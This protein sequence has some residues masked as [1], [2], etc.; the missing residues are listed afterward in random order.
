MFK[1]FKNRSTEEEIMDDFNLRGEELERTLNV[2]ENINQWLGGDLVLLSGMKEI[3][4]K[5]TDRKSRPI[6]ILDAGC[7]SGDSL[8]AVA[9]WNKKR[10][11]VL[12]LIG[13][14]ANEFTIEIAQKKAVNHPGIQ[15][16]A[17]DIFLENC[18]FV[19]VDV[20][21]CGLFMHH[22]T[23]EEQL[24]FLQ[25]CFDSDVKVVLVNDLHRHWLG[26]YLFQLICFLFR[27]PHMVKYDGSISI[28]KAFKRSDLQSLMHK[29]GIKNYDLRWRWAFRY[30]LIAYN[31]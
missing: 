26:Y 20:V 31:K 18:S 19:G 11:Y 13:L 7:G 23:E 27:V 12:N 8:R 4:P 28:L 2:I 3:L 24:S 6:T 15:F 10:G 1:K 21:V 29:A 14:D 16:L 30:Q 17:Q 5:I 25:K 9:N 22:L